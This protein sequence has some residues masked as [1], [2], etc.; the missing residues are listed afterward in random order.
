MRCALFIRS[1]WKDLE[2]LAL[3]LASI[4]R[5]CRGFQDIVVV[6]PR[7]SEPWLRRAGLP[8]VGRLEFC[9]DYRDDYLGQQATK[10]HADT[11]TTADFVCHVDSDCIFSGPVSPDDFVVDG[12]PRILMCA[13]E[14]LGRER[15]WQG[16]TEKFLGWPVSFDFMRHPPFTFPRW[17]YE[18]VRAH[19]VLEH[20]VDLDTYLARQPPRGFSEFNILGA[21]AYER[22]RDHF[23]W[24]EW[25]GQTPPA[26]PCRWYWSWGGLDTH[27]RREIEEILAAHPPIG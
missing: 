10:V 17:L 18:H 11:F 9:R 22:F 14:R 25:G 23:V 1:Y 20:G 21:L 26:S 13:L 5:Y 8:P 15:P 12:K 7:S 16:P 3:C 2:W 24:T 27:T 4:A 6:M 19:A